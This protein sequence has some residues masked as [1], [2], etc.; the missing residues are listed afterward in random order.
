MN[1]IK[2]A[3]IIA[4][5]LLLV[6]VAVVGVL[7]W[8]K[9]QYEARIVELQNV[10]AEKDKTIESKDGVYQRLA[11]QHEDLKDLLS[12][13]DEQLKSLK[14]QLDHQGS[15]L[16]T[17]NTLVIKL[18]K[19]LEAKPV[20]VPRPPD[21]NKPGIMTTDFDTEDQFAPF[22]VTGVMVAD[23]NT[24][25]WEGALLKLSQT[26]PFRFSVVVSQDKDGTWRSSTTSSEKNF[27]VDIALAAVNP[28]LLE[29]KWYEKISI[30]AEAGV[31]TNPGL[32]VGLGANYGIGKFD[33]GLRV[34]GVLD[35]GASPYFG[36]SLAWHPFKK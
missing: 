15:Q 35:R 14:E 11:V 20:I 32:L 21:T 3:L 27:E 18:K 31:G 26:R 13:K 25:K 6:I 8:K 5:V 22:K 4:G 23:C 36:A 34:W 19:D 12:S 9:N 1:Q 28:R 30:S 24:Q 2:N 33:V 29:E 17:A 16:L 10:V 7:T